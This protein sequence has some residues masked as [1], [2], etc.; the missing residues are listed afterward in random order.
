MKKLLGL[1]ILGLLILPSV[2]AIDITLD[3]QDAM[4]VFVPGINTPT[5]FTY[6]ITNN[7]ASD[8]FQFYNLLGFT[9]APNELVAINS[10][11]T[12]TVEIL[13]WPRE[14]ITTRGYYTFP[15]YIRG[16]DNSE[17]TKKLTIKLLDL[18]NAFEIGSSDF[19]PESNSISVYIQNLEKFDYTGLT[20][21]FKSKFFEQEEKFDLKSLEKKSF[22]VQLDKEDFKQLTAGFYTLEAEVSIVDLEADFNGVIKFVEKDIVEEVAK[23]YGFIINT[24]II[25]KTN[26]GN[27]VQ[28]SQTVVTKNIISRLFTTFSPEPDEVKREGVTVVYT[29]NQ[30]IKPG[31]TEEV[32]VKT[33]WF[34]PLIIVAFLAIILFFVYQFTSTDVILRKRVSFVKAKGGEFALKVTLFVHSKKYV[35]RVNIVDRLPSLVKVYNRFGGEQPAKVNEKTGL[36][37]WNFEKLEEGEIRTLSYIIYSKNVGVMGK[38]ALPAAAVIYQKDGKIHEAESNKAFFVA[39]PKKELEFE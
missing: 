38:F 32:V 33:N 5:K 17:I 24:K 35:E 25:E 31:E 29:W 22:T 13:V 11:E 23:D 15:I 8:K 20:A 37:E 14:D 16:E 1:L 36:I 27:I 12:K 39:E 3:K 2:L 28:E 21:V 34:F 30:E 10:N 19:D 7:G 4:D 18:E 26:N 6:D 9:L